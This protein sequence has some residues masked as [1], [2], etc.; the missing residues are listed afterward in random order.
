[1]VD[2]GEGADGVSGGVHAGMVCSG[3]EE[4]E[5]AGWWSWFRGAGCCEAGGW[6]GG[7]CR[8]GMREVGERGGGRGCRVLGAFIRYRQKEIK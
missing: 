2:R 7:H 8:Q 3:Y 1:V 4:G 6:V 5:G